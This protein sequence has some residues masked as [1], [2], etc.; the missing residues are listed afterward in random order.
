ALIFSM[1]FILL[2]E[3][4]TRGSVDIGQVLNTT[5]TAYNGLIEGSLGVTI[6]DTLST[7]DLNDAKAF[8]AQ[9]EITSRTINVISRTADEVAA[10]GIE[11]ALRY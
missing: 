2:T 3:L 1:L 5:G 9:T 11:T 10:T 7:D 4:F 8:A 6:S